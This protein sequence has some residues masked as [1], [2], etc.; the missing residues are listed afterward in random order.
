MYIVGMAI[1]KFSINQ[2][3]KSSITSHSEAAHR[4]HRANDRKCRSETTMYAFLYDAVLVAQGYR[5]KPQVRLLMPKP[6]MEFRKEYCHET[7]SNTK[8]DVEQS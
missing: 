6:F 1:L 7:N 8:H 3:P 2:V 4:W 5:V